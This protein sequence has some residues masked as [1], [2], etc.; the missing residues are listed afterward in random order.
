MKLQGHPKGSDRSQEHHQEW[1]IFRRLNFKCRGNKGILIVK[2]VRSTMPAETIRKTIVP[3]KIV[4]V[5]N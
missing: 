3:L 1:A 4:V 5:L 2:F